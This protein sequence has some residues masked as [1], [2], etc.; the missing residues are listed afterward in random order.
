MAKTM[1]VL[2]FAGVPLH[3]AKPVKLEE[4]NNLFADMLKKEFLSF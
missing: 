4:C 3:E 2:Q 1:R